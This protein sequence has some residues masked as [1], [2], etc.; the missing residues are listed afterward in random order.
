MGEFIAEFFIFTIAHLLMHKVVL[1][2]FTLFLF[3]HMRFLLFLKEQRRFTNE[4]ALQQAKVMVI[5]G[6]I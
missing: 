1:I 2:N 6:A 3:Y 4:A 5:G